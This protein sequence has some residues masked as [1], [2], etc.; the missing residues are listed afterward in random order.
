MACSLYICEGMILK[1]I[2]FLLL[3]AIAFMASSFNAIGAQPGALQLKYVVKKRAP[4]MAKV[5]RVAEITSEKK[6]K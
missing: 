2:R 3:C 1:I 6:K 4:V 5:P